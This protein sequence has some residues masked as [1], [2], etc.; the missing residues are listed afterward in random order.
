MAR[1]GKGIVQEN[2]L[3][4]DVGDVSGVE[5]SGGGVS[6]GVGGGEVVESGSGV[7]GGG[8]WDFRDYVGK[9]DPE[10][11][12]RYEKPEELAGYLLREREQGRQYQEEARR[13][14]QMAPYV[15]D[16]LSNADQYR[17]WKAEREKVEREEREQVKKWFD[18]PEYDPSWR[19]GI[20]QDEAGDYHVKPG[21]PPDLLQ[22]YT[23]ALQHQQG[24]LDR[25]TFDPVGSI[26]PG[27]EQ[28]IDERVAQ[29]VQQ[30]L[31]GYQELQQAQEFVKQNEGWLYEAGD[32]GQKRLSQWGQRFEDYVRE[33]EQM[34]YAGLEAQ[35]RYAL[36]SVQLDYLLSQ[37]QGQQ[38]QQQTNQAAGGGGGS[39][40]LKRQFLQ[41]AA[42]KAQAGG[43]AAAHSSSQAVP[44]PARVGG[45]H[46][47]RFTHFLA[48][49]ARQEGI[50]NGDTVLPG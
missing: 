41:N 1:A 14:Q 3:P 38:Q 9:H 24:F 33:A 42:Q 48:Q 28:L 40:D 47:N 30:R 36:K 34:G 11:L 6:E 46:V 43:S 23:R 45:G 15:Q 2:A 29:V 49:R 19:Q 21:Y 5:I 16:F 4:A 10:L 27:L 12:E 17:T 26:K 39:E 31:G 44:S 13:Y 37:A 20:Y 25:F 35:K 8:T 32:G 7:S 18:A 50:L 22:R